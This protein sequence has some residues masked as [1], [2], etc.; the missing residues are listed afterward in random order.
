MQPALSTNLLGFANNSQQSHMLFYVATDNQIHQLFY[1]GNWSDNALMDLCQQ[2]SGYRPPPPVLGPNNVPRSGTPLAGYPSGEGEWVMY[3]AQEGNSL[4]IQYMIGFSNR[5]WISSWFDIS[6]TQPASGQTGSLPAPV[7]SWGAT[8]FPSPLLALASQHVLYIAG[9]GHVI[10]IYRSGFDWVWKNRTT[11]TGALP[12]EPGS[13]LV[14]FVTPAGTASVFFISADGQICHLYEQADGQ[15]GW[16]NLSTY[17]GTVPV[18][19]P[20]RRPPGYPPLP[21]AAYMCN[22]ENTSHLIYLQTPELQ[23]KLLPVHE[24]YWQGGW[25]DHE[26]DL[27]QVTNTTPAYPTSALAGWSCEYEE[28]EHVIYCPEMTPVGILYELYHTSGGW[29]MTDVIKSAGLSYTLPD[30]AP[31]ASPLAGYA[32]EYEKTDHIWYID[33]NNCIREL[34]RSGNQ[35]YSGEKAC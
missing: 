1:Q 30:G 31:Y 32:A 26:P 24:L 33:V 16:S 17:L 10:D 8:N 29:G 23:G 22:F 28:S 12:A 5:S 35:W 3:F 21:L 11:S 15:W 7:P 34:Y 25:I 9:G 13:P 2:N 19:E 20:A 27:N 14:G 6:N 18:P 4:R